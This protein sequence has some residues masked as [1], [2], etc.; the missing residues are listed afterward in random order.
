MFSKLQK[1]G[2]DKSCCPSEIPRKLFGSSE[3]LTKFKVAKALICAR[4][5]LN[6]EYETIPNNE[7]FGF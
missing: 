6:S 3:Y 5:G 1:R 2:P 4:V 7:L